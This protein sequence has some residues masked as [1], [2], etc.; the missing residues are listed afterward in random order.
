MYGEDVLAERHCENWFAKLRS[1][2]FNEDAP[3]PGRPLEVDVDKRKS[4]LYA[5]HSIATRDIAESL[6]LS[7]A[8]VNKHMKRPGLISKLDICV[9]H[10]LPERNLLR[11]IND[12]DTLIRRQR[13]V[14]FLKRIITDDEKWF[15]YNNL[16][17][18]G[19]L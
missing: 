5:N 3:R 7:N 11:C 14:I 6:N 17:R 1:A 15:V 16:K 9:S 18:K 19:S 8:T 4:L 10:V 12:C 2:N 13:N